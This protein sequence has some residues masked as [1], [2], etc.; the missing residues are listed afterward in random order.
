ME[1]ASVAA[2]AERSRKRH[3]ALHDG[4]AASIATALADAIRA[5]AAVAAANDERS[6]R[7]ALSSLDADGAASASKRL[8]TDILATHQSLSKLGH[9][10][11]EA[12]ALD[13]SALRSERPVNMAAVNA[14]VALDLM[15]EGRAAV[16][17]RF[18]AEC[19]LALAR[20]L[21]NLC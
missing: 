2:T 3:R 4:A 19:G 16:A 15:R 18:A 1:L 5:R 17:D 12:L 9:S 10:L 8:K 21:I 13:L 7:M 6:V 20:R 11:D 14:A